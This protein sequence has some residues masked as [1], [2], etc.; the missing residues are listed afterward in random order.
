[1]LICDITPFS[2]FAPTQDLLVDAE[3]VVHESLIH[4]ID[5]FDC[6]SHLQTSNGS[7]LNCGQLSPC[8]L[9]L[10]QHLLHPVQL[11]SYD[12]KAVNLCLQ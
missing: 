10:H 7:Q 12:A 3:C 8:V 6:I 9:I 4:P 1:M 5:T 2:A 11:H